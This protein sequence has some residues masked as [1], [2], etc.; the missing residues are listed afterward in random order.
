ME[1]GPSR[2]EYWSTGPCL[3]KE[4]EEHKKA[5]ECIRKTD[6]GMTLNLGNK[7]GAKRSKDEESNRN[8]KM[9]SMDEALCTRHGVDHADGI[10]GCGEEED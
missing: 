3:V 8:V 9:S 4:K 6:V 1:A 5:D 10:S 2:F 7:G